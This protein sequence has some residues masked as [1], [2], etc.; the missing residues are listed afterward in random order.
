MAPASFHFPLH[1]YAVDSTRYQETSGSL[2]R[3]FPLRDYPTRDTVNYVPVI[4]SRFA[5]KADKEDLI[6]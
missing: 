3:F 2:H 6:Y 4:K 1:Y 5:V